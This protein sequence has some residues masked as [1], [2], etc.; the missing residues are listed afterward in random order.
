MSVGDFYVGTLGKAW[1]FGG[2]MIH[3]EVYHD[4]MANT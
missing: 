2:R 4:N 1:R 3:F